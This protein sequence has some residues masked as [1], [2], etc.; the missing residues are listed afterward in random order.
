MPFF[1]KLAKIPS[2]LSYCLVQLKFF[3]KVC[4][5]SWHLM[6]LTVLRVR[7]LIPVLTR[8]K[9]NYVSVHIKMLMLVKV[10][11]GFVNNFQLPHIHSEH[12]LNALAIFVY[13]ENLLG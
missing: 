9:N 8:K 5:F 13:L 4:L 3:M 10:I 11:A 12:I 6:P 1:S 2:Q 7:I